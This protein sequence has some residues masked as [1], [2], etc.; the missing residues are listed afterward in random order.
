MYFDRNYSCQRSSPMKTK[1][2][3]M[4]AITVLFMFVM[5]C[6]TSAETS[7]VNNT[8]QPMRGD[9]EKA[10]IQELAPA[11]VVD[12]GVPEADIRCIQACKD[13]RDNCYG[14]CRSRFHQCMQRGR[15]DRECLNGYEGCKSG[16]GSAFNRCFSA[17]H[18]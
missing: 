14:L 7:A 18:H 9:L 6:S 4:P 3:L 13:R 8:D 1:L 15:P 11:V 2:L 10:D 16:C 17:C 5:C 12:R